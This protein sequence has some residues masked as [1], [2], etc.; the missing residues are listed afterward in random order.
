[1][2]KIFILTALI[3]TT[4]LAQDGPPGTEIILADIS[5]NKEAVKLSNEV[6]ITNSKGYDSQ[7]AYI[8]DGIY[9]TK[10]RNNQSDI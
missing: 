3:S 5:F 4:I 2:K 6:N 1:M 9:F 8:D 7:P 10:F